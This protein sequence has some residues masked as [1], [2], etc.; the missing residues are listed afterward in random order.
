M[1]LAPNDLFSW[2]NKYISTLNTISPTH[3]LV[4]LSY[5]HHLLCACWHPEAM[6]GSSSLTSCRLLILSRLPSS[7]IWAQ[8]T[9]LVPALGIRSPLPKMAPPLTGPAHLPLPGSGTVAIVSSVSAKIF[10]PSKCWRVTI[11][12]LLHDTL[13]NQCLYCLLPVFIVWLLFVSVLLFD[14]V[15][16]SLLCFCSIRFFCSVFESFSICSVLIL[17]MYSWYFDPVKHQSSSSQ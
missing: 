10:N 3:S 12:L 4:L 16:Y 5:A 9:L 6:N 11:Q 8:L 7:L 14:S 17:E 15:F 2:N 1:V 13:L